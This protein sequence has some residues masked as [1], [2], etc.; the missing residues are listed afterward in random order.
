MHANSC[1][2]LCKLTE[3]LFDIQ[4]LCG[5]AYDGAGAMAGINIGVS[6]C[7]YPKAMYTCIHGNITPAQPLY[8]EVL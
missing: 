3:W 7:K 2:F 1:D 6:A 5:Q 4:L 8:H